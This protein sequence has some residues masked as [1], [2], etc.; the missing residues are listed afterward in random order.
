MRA[1]LKVNGITGEMLIRYIDSVLAQ[2]IA[3][4]D[5]YPMYL[6]LDN[7]NVH[8]KQKMIDA[9]RDRGCQNLKD[10]VF[11]PADGAKRLDPLDNGIFGV[12]KQ[13]CRNH[14]NISQIDMKHIMSLEWNKIDSHLLRGCYNHCLYARNADVYEDCPQPTVHHHQSML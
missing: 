10:I 7:S 4:L 9:F 13:R 8:N 6:I 1:R 14:N 11:M 5:R 3:A 12:W 2:S